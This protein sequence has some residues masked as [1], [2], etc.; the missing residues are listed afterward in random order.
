[1]G[2]FGK[3]KKSQMQKQFFR[4]NL[5][6]ELDY[7]NNLANLCIRGLES[8]ENFALQN[9]A[10]QFANRMKSGGFDDNTDSEI[11]VHAYI[12]NTLS[13]LWNSKPEISFSE[14]MMA[15]Y[16]MAE[17]NQNLKDQVKQFETGLFEKLDEILDESEDT[18]SLDSVAE[19]ED[20]K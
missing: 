16:K 7:E 20:D 17:E 14:F 6:Y 3:K 15:V 8:L 2:L 9:P 1:M 5:G 18:N 11:V 10:K 4:T 13:E 12:A 19:I